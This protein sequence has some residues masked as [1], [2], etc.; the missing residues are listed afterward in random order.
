LGWQ[1]VVADGFAD[2]GDARFGALARGDAAGG[3]NVKDGVCGECTVHAEGVLG[4]DHD[5]RTRHD[6]GDEGEDG[7]AVLARGWSSGRAVDRFAGLHEWSADILS[8]SD[9]T[10]LLLDG[11][12]P[13]PFAAFPYPGTD[14]LTGEYD[15]NSF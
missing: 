14:Q 15:H 5:S 8:A 13:I 4:E 11:S 6:Q 12:T 3:V 2:G 10:P 7:C 9:G 1:S